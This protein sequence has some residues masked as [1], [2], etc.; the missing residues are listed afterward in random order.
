MNWVKIALRFK[1]LKEVEKCMKVS[2]ALLP[3][4]QKENKMGNINSRSVTVNLHKLPS[5]LAIICC[6]ALRPMMTKHNTF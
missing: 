3:Q 2:C 1:I 5:H 4:R 6:L